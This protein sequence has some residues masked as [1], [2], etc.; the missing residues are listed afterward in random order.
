MLIQNKK[1]LL[2]G[3]IFLFI[4]PWT[5]SKIEKYEPIPEISQESN[6]F[7]EINPCRVSLLE[8]LMT[9]PKSIFQEHYF[10]RSFDYTPINCFGKISGVSVLQSGSETQ[11]F[12]SVGTNSFINLL[13]QS[14][15]WIFVLSFIPINRFENK[16]FIKIKTRNTLYL[17]SAALFSFSI[18]AEKRFYEDYLYVFD[19]NNKNSYLIIFLTFFLVS[20]FLCELYESRTEE[21]F[22]YLP[23]IFLITAL[24]SGFNLT[25][26][27]LLLAY[28]GLKKILY[29][30][31]LKKFNNLY[32]F[33]SFWWLFN[34]HGSYFFKVAKFRGFTSSIYEFN[35]NLFWIIYFLLIINGIFQFYHETNDGVKLE[36]FISQLSKSSFLILI[37]GIVGSNFPIVSFLQYY[38]LGL[39]R[40]VV[41]LTNPFIFDE[42]NIKVSW[43]G[44][45]PSSET[46]GEFYGI[47]LIF[48][49][50]QIVK[51]NK[52]SKTNLIGIFASAFGIY[53]SD[54]RTSILLVFLFTFLYLIIKN[55][56]FSK[57]QY[58]ILVLIL[59]MGLSVL[60]FGVENLTSS[61]EFSSSALKFNALASQYDNV[62]S[63]FML[64][65][66]DEITE[67]R[68]YNGLFNS[69][70]I[71]ALLLNRSER[72]GVFFSRYNPTFMEFY[73]GSGPLNFGQIYGETIINEQESLL[74]PHSSF[75]SYVVFFGLMPVII[76]IVKYSLK[77]LNKKSSIETKILFVYIIVNSFKNDSLNYF[78]LFCF[79]ILILLFLDKSKVSEK[80]FNL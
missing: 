23:Y 29:N 16:S 69:F 52:I 67:N 72:W 79:Y 22:N 42:Y 70:S 9:N 78:V 77:F 21:I 43:R 37:F 56:S 40:Y 66:T 5:F 62:N 7:Y 59:I 38:Y 51:T 10:F 57:K 26:Y 15:F 76:L 65:I 55:F 4:V 46:I 3:I 45:F 20:K 24:F 31:T 14:F 32:V 39:Q 35:A 80:F 34:S 12:I 28:L 60:L 6:A 74:L 47:V 68:F 63:S 41:N 33:L 61:Y 49:L 27:S 44:I 58:L 2:F 54:N 48:I 25:I 11:F 71:I 1:I 19:F 18:Y 36:K 30:N 64:Y 17:I 53:F 75:L 13:I 73:L 8:F 50:F